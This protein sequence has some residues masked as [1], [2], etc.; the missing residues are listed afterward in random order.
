MAKTNPAQFVRE[1]R[2]EASKVTWPTRKETGISTAMVFVFCI[3]AAI[4]FLAVDQVL[5]LGVK[6]LFGLGG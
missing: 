5:Q 1:V 2:Q 6:F 4:F 3:I